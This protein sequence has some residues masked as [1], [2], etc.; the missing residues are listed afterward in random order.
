MRGGRPHIDET[1][2]IK[3]L[4]LQSMYNLPDES[5]EKELHDRISFRDFLHYPEI[6]P[7]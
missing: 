1:V 3:T 5:M 7:D 2:M 6:L 4:F